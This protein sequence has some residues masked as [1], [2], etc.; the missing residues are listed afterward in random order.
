[1]LSDS[2]LKALN[3][4][5]KHEYYSSY[6]YLSMAAHFEAATLPGFAHWMKVQSQEELGHALKFFAYINDQ[7]GR[8]TLQ[9]IDQPPTQF[10]SALSIFQQSLEHERKVTGLIRGLCDLA[11][12]E[13]DYA[14]QTMLQWFVSEQVE[15]EKN[16]SQI[17]EQLKMIGEQGAALFML[18][19]QLGSRAD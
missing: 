9:A 3:D 10:G 17:V 13:N 7:G 11:N 15:E 12:K 19:A 14:T 16:A 2:M 1:M 5:I 8:V 18:N 6:L 4:Q